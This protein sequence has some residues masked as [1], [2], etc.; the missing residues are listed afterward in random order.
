MMA[1][2]GGAH[3][4]GRS[5][6]MSN[7]YSKT[8]IPIRSQEVFDPDNQPAHSHAGDAARKYCRGQ[9]LGARIFN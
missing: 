2:E 6:E 8:Q 9:D 7:L 4:F 3:I 5:G 1:N